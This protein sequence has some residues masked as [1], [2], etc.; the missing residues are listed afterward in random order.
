MSFPPFYNKVV[1]VSNSLKLILI[2]Q[3]EVKK[4]KNPRKPK[5]QKKTKH[6]H[7][8]WCKNNGFILLICFVYVYVRG[9]IYI[10]IYSKKSQLTRKRVEMSGVD[11]NNK[12]KR[13]TS[14]TLPKTAFSYVSWEYTF[15]DLTIM[16]LR[17]V[18]EYFLCFCRCVAFWINFAETSYSDLKASLD[19]LIHT[20]DMS[21]YL[22]GRWSLG[23][24]P[25]GH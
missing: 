19:K 3:V 17:N 22:K 15:Y 25:V 1:W 11:W 20:I 4:K 18:S 6:G 24:I 7:C 16:F 13:A 21:L 12:L 2:S 14:R 10:C 5:K 8:F 23:D 9:M